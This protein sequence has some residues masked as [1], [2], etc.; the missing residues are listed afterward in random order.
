[1][2][3]MYIYD[4]SIMLN[5]FVSFEHSCISYAYDGYIYWYAC[6]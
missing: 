1:M 2:F 4:S 3:V 6:L 5:V